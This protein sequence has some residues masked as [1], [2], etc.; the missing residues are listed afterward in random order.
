MLMCATA[1]GSHRLKLCVV[2][3]YRRPRCLKNVMDSLPL[4]YYHNRSAWFDREI[5]SSWFFDHAIPE[6]YKDQIERQKISHENVKALILIDNAPAHPS[7]E[8]LCSKEGNIKVMFLPPNTT[9]VIQPMDQGVIECCK[10]FYLTKLMRECFVVI[11]SEEDRVEDTHGL[12]TL[13]NLK[14]YNL[15]NALFNLADAWQQ[16]SV[17]TLANAWK[18]LIQDMDVLVDFTGFEPEDFVAEMNRGGSDDVMEEDVIDWLQ[19][20]ADD[21]GYHHTTD[22][23]IVESVS[24][25]Q[26]V[27]EASDNEEMP[28]EDMP[29]LSRIRQ[30][31]DEVLKWLDRVHDRHVQKYYSKLRDFRNAIIT[32]QHAKQKQGKIHDFFKPIPPRASSLQ[33]SHSSDSSG[34]HIQY[35]STDDE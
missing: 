15:C 5:F 28:D 6:I 25:S 35:T 30:C 2:G 12:R 13:E 23:E 19:I 33:Q 20:D 27:T 32:R 4:H 8:I 34:L 26:E 14:N 11:E 24:A 29:K 16:V 22:A 10:W 21:P 3:K 18:K 31:M 7:G 17:L 9:S 1:D